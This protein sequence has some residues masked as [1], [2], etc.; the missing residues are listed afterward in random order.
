[1]PRLKTFPWYVMPNTD[2]GEKCGSSTVEVRDI[3]INL[4][5]HKAL[6]T[7]HCQLNKHDPVKQS[8]ECLCG[9]TYKRVSA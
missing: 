9:Y 1:M 7:H 3:T 8:C 4:V 6:V 5:K 2:P